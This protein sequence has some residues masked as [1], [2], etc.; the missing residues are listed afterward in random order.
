M[1]YVSGS[2]DK[3][4][5]AVALGAKVCMIFCHTIV[6]RHLTGLLRLRQD[7]ITNLVS[8][9][10]LCIHIDT[11]QLPYRHMA[12]RIGKASEGTECYAGCCDRLS[13]RRHS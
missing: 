9:L 12:E 2:E 8:H 6:I 5:K 3:I 7:S 4:A 13:W 10:C 11:F 1:Y